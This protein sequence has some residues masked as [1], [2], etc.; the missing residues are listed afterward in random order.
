LPYPDCG[1]D[2]RQRGAGG[3]YLAQNPARGRFDASP[4]RGR[5]LLVNI[6]FIIRPKRNREENGPVDELCTTAS[7]DFAVFLRRPIARFEPLVRNR[8][9]DDPVRRMPLDLLAVGSVGGEKE[10]NGIPWRQPEAR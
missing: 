9:I 8:Q 7:A 1:E 4:G 2:L 5:R 3:D 10:R 6:I